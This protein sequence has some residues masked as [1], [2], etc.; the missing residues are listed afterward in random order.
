M[1]RDGDIGMYIEAGTRNSQPCESH[2]C[3]SVL[4]VYIE[5]VA[6]VFGKY[7]FGFVDFCGR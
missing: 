5:R 4:T 2:N 1:L 3:C 6:S 7:W